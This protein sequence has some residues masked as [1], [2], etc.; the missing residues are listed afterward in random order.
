MVQTT[1]NKSKLDEVVADLRGRGIEPVVKNTICSATRKR[2]DA[3]SVEAVRAAVRPGEVAVL[4][5]KSGVGKSS[6]VNVLVGKDIQAT[7]AVRERDGRGR[8]TTV[9]QDR[10]SY[11]QL[12]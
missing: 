1:E 2:Q 6:L 5:G 10:E 9:S 4:L 12:G 3:E 11:R 7:G 8:H